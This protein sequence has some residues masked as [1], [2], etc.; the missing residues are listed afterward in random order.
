VIRLIVGLALATLVNLCG[1][2]DGAEQHM[3]GGEELV[4]EVL[5][6]HPGPQALAQA[7][8]AAEARVGPAGAL[9]DP[10]LGWAVAP[11]TIDD[12]DLGTRQ[13]WQISQ[14]IPWP[15]KLDLKREAAQAASQAQAMDLE[16]LRLQV[17]EQA[18]RQFGQW[19]L[20]HQALA[21]NADD[22]ALLRE[23][24]EVATQLYASGRGTQQ[25]V[26]QA[27]L[28][29]VSLRR[30]AL[31]LVKRQRTIAATINAL[32]DQPVETPLG[33]P[34]SWPEPPG[35]PPLAVL[36]ET[37]QAR[38]P[39]LQALDARER[40]YAHRAELAQ[41]DRMPDLRLNL[42][43]LGT[44][45]PPE[46]RLQAGVSL[47]LPLNFNRR[48]QEV[49]AA[50]ADVQ[51]A[52]WAQRDLSGQVA[53]AVAGA[54]AQVQQS[55]QTLALYRNE[56]LPLARQNLA[57]AQADWQ[58]GAGDFQAVVDAQ[59]QLLETRLGVE[60]ARVEEWTARAALAT[61]VADSNLHLFQ[62]TGP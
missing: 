22:Q 26:L 38:Q 34:A 9:P 24:G 53:A 14:A 21:I 16:S 29:E 43:H 41:R 36:I 42:S 61:Q 46:K 10:V 30:E 17:V 51:R 2:A 54:H 35:L 48:R 56:L 32:R 18:R 37:A 47:N 5:A 11:E 23:L 40:M 52:H 7:L 27:G 39:A 19:Y 15:G 57:A 50:R 1:A 4:R 25:A 20:V 31:E 28:R 62:E 45:D 8:A 60:R 58:T 13:I 12:E 49:E 3:L 6:R 44:L 55:R 33:A 59:Q